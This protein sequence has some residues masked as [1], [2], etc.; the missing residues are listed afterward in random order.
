MEKVLGAMPGENM[1]PKADRVL[2]I[3]GEHPIFSKLQ[4]LYDNDK[5]KLSAYADI[6]YDQAL[7]IEGLDIDDP[8]DYCNKIC[9]LMV[10]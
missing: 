8:V 7:L 5:D 10:G 6:L 4:F 2:E 3:N 1:K 9:D